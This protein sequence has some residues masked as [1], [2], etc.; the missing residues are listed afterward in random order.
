MSSSSSVSGSSLHRRTGQSANDPVI[1]SGSLRSSE[2]QAPKPRPIAQFLAFGFI[3]FLCFL[4]FLPATHFRDPSDPF[5]KWVPFNSN[6]SSSSTESMAS[7]N[8]NP[9]YIITNSGEDGMVHIVSYMDCLDL[10]LLV[11]LANS[12][13][14]SSR[15][16]E[17]ISFHFFIPK[18][19]DDKVS[20]YKLKVLFPHSNLE[21]R[22]QEEVKE[23]IMKA[24]PLGKYEEPPFDEIAP[25][26]IPIVHPSLR[27]F[28][29]VSP[30]LI[31]KGR[32][33]ELLGIDLSNYDIAAAEDCSKRL[34]AYVNFDV[35]DAIHRSAAKPWVSGTPYAKN[36]CLPDLSLILIDATKLDKDLVQA[37]LWWTKVLNTRERSS[38]NPAVALALY[39]RYLKLPSSWMVG[40]LATSEISNGR[41][42][43]R[44]GGN[45]RVCSEF[46][47]RTIEKSDLGDL[48]KQYLPPMS[49]QILGH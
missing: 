46:S 42:V 22:G 23:E 30:N 40:N 2:D 16:P 12:T 8:E 13:L 27:K 34:S 15:D 36:A 49:D 3:I 31:M 1:S 28:I 47:S 21:I 48:W 26:V 25:F 38:P 6:L 7:S 37:I 33:E 10:R 19:C 17:R 45:G 14:S 35:L 41:L 18:G 29:Y 5:R 20:Y 39:K 24:Y 9:S 32:V 43:L 4:Q 11:A 44:Y